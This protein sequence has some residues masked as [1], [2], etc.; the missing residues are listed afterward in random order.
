M[1]AVPVHYV[2]DSVVG[3]G[4]QTRWLGRLGWPLPSQLGHYFPGYGLV[5]WG[6]TGLLHVACAGDLVA[7]GLGWMV[8]RLSTSMQC[9]QGYV[10]LL[11]TCWPL[12]GSQTSYRW[13][14]SRELRCTG[15]EGPTRREPG[16]RGFHFSLI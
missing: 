1:K 11:T 6:P 16:E 4:V 14:L 9:P 3:T 15:L 10:G 5:V 2:G 8:G 12:S 7:T 13:G